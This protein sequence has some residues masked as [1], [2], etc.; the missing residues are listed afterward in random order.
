MPF[1]LMYKNTYTV[2]P[3]INKARCIYCTVF[4]RGADKSSTSLF[5]SIP[6]K[7]ALG[8]IKYRD[9]F[10]FFIFGIYYIV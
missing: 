10:W 5:S 9:I 8:P 2:L 4:H 3:I 1:N 7:I 6:Y